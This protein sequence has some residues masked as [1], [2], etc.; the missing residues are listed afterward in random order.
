M[1]KKMKLITAAVLALSLSACGLFTPDPV[2]V[3]PEN[4]KNLVESIKYVKASNGICFGVAGVGKMSTG[5][6]YNESQMI[7]VV[8]C[9]KVGL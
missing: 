6:T 4:A 1:F 3:N 8:D 9:V 5:G 7:V 2:K